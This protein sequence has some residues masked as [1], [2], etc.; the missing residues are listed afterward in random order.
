MS[1]LHHTPAYLALSARMS[2]TMDTAFDTVA[3]GEPLTELTMERQP[4]EA[5]P[6]GDAL[7]DALLQRLNA[8]G[9]NAR[10]TST[11]PHAGITV[12]FG[13]AV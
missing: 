9:V 3:R 11:D 2:K 13:Q 5:T 6:E 1:D 12:A 8:S 4:G 10:W 7:Y